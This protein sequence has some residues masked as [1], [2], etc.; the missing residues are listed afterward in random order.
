MENGQISTAHYFMYPGTEYRENDVNDNYH[1]ARWE[2][3]PVMN[4]ENVLPVNFQ[5]EIT[6]TESTMYEKCCIDQRTQVDYSCSA[7]FRGWVNPCW[8]NES[9][10]DEKRDFDCPL[11]DGEKREDDRE[12]GATSSM[13]PID[14]S[15]SEH[16]ST[17]SRRRRSN[18]D[19]PRK[20]RTA[21]TKQQVRHLEYEFSHSN[22]LTRLRRYEIAITLDLTERQVKVW[23]QNRRMKHKRI[24]EISTHFES[25][26]KSS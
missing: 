9:C 14:P 5:P 6:L 19:K 17:T 11:R 20:E 2:E 18:T 7:A 24:K 26:K 13:E 15:D 4:N 8:E 1:P 21:F 3:Y 16:D 12:E 10:V 23:F 25:A 22:Y